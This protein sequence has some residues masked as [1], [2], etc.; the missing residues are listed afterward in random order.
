[1]RL[2][3]VLQVYAHMHAKVKTGM[4]SSSVST[5]GLIRIGAFYLK[6]S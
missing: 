6:Q 5:V 2:V 3:T 4:G 1:M